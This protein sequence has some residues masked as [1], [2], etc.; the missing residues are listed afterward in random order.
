MRSFYYAIAMFW[1]LIPA[2]LAQ[3]SGDGQF[4]LRT[5]DVGDLTFE[6]KDHPY[7]PDATQSQGRGGAMGGGGLGGGGFYGGGG[8][9]SFHGGVDSINGQF[10][11]GA[12][13]Q[14]SQSESLTIEGLLNAIVTTIAANTWSENDPASPGRISTVGTAIVVWQTPAVHEHIAGLL[15]SLRATVADRRT[16]RIDARWLL[17]NSG[18]LDELVSSED[19]SIHREVLD[20][21]TRQPSTIRAITNCFSGQRVHLVSGTRRGIVQSYIPVVGSVDRSPNDRPS[22]A[23]REGVS[24]SLISDQS[25]VP[26]RGSVGYQPVISNANFG[27]LLEIQPRMLQ[28]SNSVVVDL[29][30]TITVPS[31][32]ADPALTELE[33]SGAAPVVDRVAIETQVLSTTLAMPVGKPFLAGGMTYAPAVGQFQSAGGESPQAGPSTE[34]PQLYLVLQID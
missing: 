22:V 32:E 7:R 34:Q 23:R 1:L 8:G 2:A 3:D 18:D 12:G 16:L 4:Q 24:I 17:L 28:R 15:D 30:S 25:S 21:L 31:Q 11:G 13:S 33:A 6:I 19:G 29:T 27:A 26:S 5:Y 14:V 10:G 9:G 20:R